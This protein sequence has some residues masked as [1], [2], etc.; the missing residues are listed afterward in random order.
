MEHKITKKI[1]W[2]KSVYK[3]YQVFIRTFYF[4]D[5]K[6]IVIYQMG[7][8]GS[9]SVLEALN[10]NNLFPVFQIHRMN[11]DHMDQIRADYKQKNLKLPPIR[12][13]KLLYHEI[14][15]KKRGAKFITLVR[16]PINRNISAFFENIQNYVSEPLDQVFDT[17]NL[18]KLF[19]EKYPQHV[20][21]DWFDIEPKVVLGIDVFNYPF[22]KEKGFLQIT[23][24][25]F[26]WLII[27]TEIDDR[28]KENTIRDYLK[29]D[30]LSLKKLNL[31]TDKAFGNYFDRFKKE[32][33]LPKDYLEKMKN[34]KYTN[35]FYTSSELDILWARWL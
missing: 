6:P 16:D 5:E 10:E 18:T 7:K 34:A 27:K 26:D 30:V 1:K 4:G 35:H 14:I 19:L 25:K 31:T 23:K 17:G 32:L 29:I 22:P 13:K 3:I 21:L 2:F 11:P 15:A 24:G 20:P 12:M 8:V 9:T 28:T 33:K